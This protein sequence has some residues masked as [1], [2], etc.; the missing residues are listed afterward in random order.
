MA[1]DGS[2]EEIRK[3]RLQEMQQSQSQQK[4]QEMQQ[5][6]DYVLMQLLQP[7]AKARLARIA[8]VKPEK[9]R[10]VEDIILQ[11]ARSGALREK[12]DEH[13]LKGLLEKVADQEEKTTVVIKRR[14]FFD[15]EDD[16]D[17]SDL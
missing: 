17:F 1:E 3:K 15:D 4:Q 11:A 12:V 6:R 10:M 16:E 13:Y 14:T 2:L 8:L 7:D 5:Q 9:A